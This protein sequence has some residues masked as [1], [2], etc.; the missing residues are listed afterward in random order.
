[1]HKN[2]GLTLVEVIVATVVLCLV[3]LGMSSLFVAGKRHVLNSRDRMSASQMWKIFV[4]PLQNDVR[5]DN[6]NS[7]ANGLL[8]DDTKAVAGEYTT[9]CGTVAG[10]T[11][12]NPICPSSGSDSVNNID[13]T[14]KYDLSLVSDTDLRRVKAK[15][16]W[17][18]STP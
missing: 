13:Y 4:N 18:E 5:Q 7:T 3:I 16:S 1:M 17:V 12:Q 14:A 9:C 6:L 15:I 10:C 2:A 8:W 11:I